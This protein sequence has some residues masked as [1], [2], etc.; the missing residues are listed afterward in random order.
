MIICDISYS[1]L[2]ECNYL[3]VCMGRIFDKVYIIICLRI[4]IC[5]NN[6][7]SNC[8]YFANYYLT[9]QGILK[10]TKHYYNK[11]IYNLKTGGI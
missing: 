1:S 10:Y 3:L 2:Y 4:I 5:D 11:A 6:I 9:Y 8:T 7:H